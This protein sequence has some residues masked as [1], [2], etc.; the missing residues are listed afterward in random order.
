V[1]PPRKPGFG[2][3][4]PKLPPAPKGRPKVPPAMAPKMQ[5]SFGAAAPAPFRKGGRVGKGKC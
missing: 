1:A 4:A 3:A 2:P 5:K